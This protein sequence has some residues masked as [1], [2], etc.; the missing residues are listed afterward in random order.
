[1]ADKLSSLWSR[2]DALSTTGSVVAG[3]ALSGLMSHTEAAAQQPKRGGTLRFSTRLDSTGLDPHRNVIYPVSMPLAAISQGLL[4]LDLKSEPAPGVAA[5]WAHTP[6]LLTYTFKLRKGALFHNGREIDAAAG[7][8]TS[9][10][11]IGKQWRILGSVTGKRRYIDSEDSC[12]SHNHQRIIQKQK[13]VSIRP[14]TLPGINKPNPSNCAL[15]PASLACGSSKASARM[16]TIC[17]RRY[18]I[19]SLK[20]L[21]RRIC[22]RP[23]PCWMS[24]KHS[25]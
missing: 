6:D 15:L 25:S 13:P 4:D 18:T 9:S 21:A 22:R 2:R 10:A 5:E 17:C 14:L 24:W 1:M 7:N 3:I 12:F 19:G 8:G 11:S 20:A 23:K 16:P